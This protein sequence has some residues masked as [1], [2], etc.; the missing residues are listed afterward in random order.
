M[1]GPHHGQDGRIDEDSVDGSKLPLVIIP[2]TTSQLSNF[3]FVRGKAVSMAEIR[4][5]DVERQKS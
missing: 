2:K 4:E 1:K 5:A 3:I